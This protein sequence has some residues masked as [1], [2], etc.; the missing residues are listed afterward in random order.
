MIATSRAH[1]STKK[2]DPVRLAGGLASGG[3][4]ENSSPLRTLVAILAAVSA[5]LAATAT[6][7]AT[8]TATAQDRT[9]LVI[10]NYDYGGEHVYSRTKA[11][12][13]AVSDALRNEGFRVTFV[14]NVPA[15]QL[16]NTFEQFARGTV[17]RGVS[18]CYFAGLAGQY[19]TYNSKGAWWNHLQGAGAPAD[20]RNPER[21]S[22]ALVDVIKLFGD[23]SSSTTNL[24]VIDTPAENPFLV[25]RAKGPISLGAIEPA[26]LPPDLGVLVS[27]RIGAPAEQ[28]LALADAFAKHLPRGRES[29]SA[30]RTA[31]LSDVKSRAAVQPSPY[32]VGDARLDAASWPTTQPGV[33]LDSDSPRVGDKAGQQWTNS[34]G[35]VF[36]WCPPGSFRMGNS[37]SGRPEFADAD[38]V[39]VTLSNGFWIGK[40]EVT[41]AEADRLKAG[42][43]RY[44][45][46]GR[47]LPVHAV[48][49]GQTN[50]LISALNDAERKAGRLPNDWEYALPTEAQWEY[51]CRAGTTTRY[52]FGDDVAMLARHANFADKCLLDDDDSLRFAD[53]RFVDGVGRTLAV[54]GSYRP[55]PWGLHDMHGNVAE[56]CADRYV[57]N[58]IG[59]VDPLVDDKRKDASPDGII[60]GGA[61][62]SVPAYCESAFRNSEFS[63]GNAKNRDFLGFRLILKRK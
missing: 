17:T 1:D 15:K 4:R 55:N 27:F 28:S 2:N 22:I 57:P 38:S 10:A 43:G 37:E 33:F 29:L 58:L 7:N 35:M 16:K 50:K 44:A 41:Q 39:E 36:C 46:P 23:H 30:W 54:V 48:Q 49:Q 24:L 45:F 52:S 62:C 32:F 63:G 18:I 19:Q 6:T 26:D 14:E 8:K 61:W 25:A 12:T 60:R 3:A 59:G 51:A 42:A 21:E 47:H 31:V 5:A 13:A 20:P 53:A 34:F 56:W 9:A 11:E 40:Y